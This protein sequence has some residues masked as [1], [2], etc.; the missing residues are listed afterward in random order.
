MPQISAR[1]AVWFT[2]FSLFS[3]LFYSCSPDEGVLTEGTSAEEDYGP[4]TTYTGIFATYNSAYR[5]TFQLEISEA[6][7]EYEKSDYHA[8]AS[9]TI[10]TGEIYTAKF[11]RAEEVSKS[12]DFK[13]TFDSADFSFIFS[14]DAEGK[15]VF[16]DVVFKNEPGAIVAAEETTNKTLTPIT[17]TYKCTNCQDKDSINGIPLNNEDRTFNM[18]LTTE[19]GS[20]SMTIQASLGILVDTEVIVEK[21]CTTAGEYTICEFSNGIYGSNEPVTWTGVHRFKTLTSD[22][23]ST[24]SSISGHI[25]FESAEA[26]I[27][28][29][30]FFSDSTC[31]EKTYYV[32][33]SGDD[34]NSGFSPEEA[35]SSIDKLNSMDLQPGDVILFEGG[36]RFNGNLYLDAEDANNSASP[37][38]IGSYGTGKAIIDAGDNFGIYAYNT[39]GIKIDNIIVAG[40]GAQTNNNTG[41]LFYNDLSGDIKLDLVEITNT[42]VYGFREAGITI[43][44]YNGNSGYSNVLIENNKVHDCLDKGITSY[45]KFSSTKTGY[46]HRNIM[47]RNCEVFNI[48]GYSK[49]SHSGNGIVLSDVQNSVIEHCTAYNCGSG[50]TNCGGPVGIWYWDADQVTIQYCEA[51]NISSG[52][53]CDGG[54]FDLDG[55]VTNG[56]MQ[57]NYS[58]DNDGAGY[59]IGQFTGARAMKNIHVRYNISQNDAA[60]NGGSVYLFNGNAAMQDIYI[61]N[62]TLYL[63]EESSNTAS[64]NVKYNSWYPVKNNINFFNNIFFAE[65]GADLVSIPNGYDGNFEGNLYYTSGNFSLKY[66]GTTYASLETFRNTG[67]EIFEDLPS[68][69]EGR[70]LLANPGNGRTIGYGNELSAL[71]AYELQEGSPAINAGVVIPVERGNRDFYGNDLRENTVPDIG[72]QV[73]LTPQSRAGV[74]AEL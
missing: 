68:G 31:P 26:G 12:S 35:W 24:C 14:L 45:G 61:Y 6:T 74:I 58:H 15:P 21:S 29:G 71:K 19:D 49:N 9:L 60:T 18:M 56:T 23:T 2:A 48:E 34:A 67:N 38:K 16:T 11:V 39:S 43:G 1:K 4:T 55:G 62:N 47:V 46:A 63:K 30:D 5:G 32:S 8:N 57:Y 73:N 66:K 20:S 25:R 33:A 54:G 44:A 59:L 36:Q 40:S 51:Y 72:A 42:E 28:E 70:P 37:V 22:S 7:F 3:I 52:S 65:N 10:Q 17:G 53:G 50:N 69:Y 41:I 27:I 64:A 13:L